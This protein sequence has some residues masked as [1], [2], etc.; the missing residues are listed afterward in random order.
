MRKQKGSLTV[1]A[2]LIVPLVLTVF[3]LTVNAGISLYTEC[4]EMAAA[5]MAREDVDAAQ[6]FYAR[7]RVKDIA[8]YGDSLH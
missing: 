3:A 7:E 8:K 1:E 2:A 5:A 4:R 6:L